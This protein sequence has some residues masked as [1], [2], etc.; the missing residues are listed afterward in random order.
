MRIVDAKVIVCCPG[1]KFV[2]LKIVTQDEIH[3]LGDATL[4][5]REPGRGAWLTATLGG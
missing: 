2:I 5:G 1:R 4:N 3:G